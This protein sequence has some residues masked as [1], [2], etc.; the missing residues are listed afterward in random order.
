[1][2]AITRRV[3]VAAVLALSTL[4]GAG[5]AISEPATTQFKPLQGVS[6]HLGTKHAIGYYVA[7]SRVCQL[8]LVV[9]DVMRDDDVIPT[10]VSARFRAA[11]AAGKT[12][13]FDT[14]T[15]TGTEL[16]FTCGPDAAA[17]SV[18]PLKQVAY[19]APRK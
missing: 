3:G 14:G 9:G 4:I 19:S 17:M 8:T 5:A 6:M 1:M 12:V 15:D 13:R 16:Q 18:I 2:T 7:D 11:V 10:T